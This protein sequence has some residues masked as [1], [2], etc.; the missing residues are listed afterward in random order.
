LT[1]EQQEPILNGEFR[2][3]NLK[4]GEKIMAI[5]PEEVLRIRTFL[6]SLIQQL[7]QGFREVEK[8][9]IIGLRI[10]PKIAP[11]EKAMLREFAHKLLLLMR[12]YEASDI[13]F[14]GP[15]S[16]SMIWL[17]VYGQK[18]PLPELGRFSLDEFSILIQC[19]LQETQQKQLYK[20][21]SIDFSYVV[22]LPDQPRQRYRATVYFEMGELALNM[23][24]IQTRLRPYESYGFHENVSRTLSLRYNKEGLIL[25]TGITGSGKTTT[26]DAII[27]LNNREVE[28]HIIVLASPIEFIHQSQKCIIRQREVGLDTL[29]FK[30]GVIEALHQDPDIIIIGEM[31]DPE[32]IM[33]V[34]EAADSGH[35]VFSTLHTASAVES[36]ER[37]IA[38]MPSLEQDRVRN[39]LADTLRCV[40]SQKLVPGINGK[41]ALAKEIMIMT[42][43]VKAAIKNNNLSEVYQ[44]VN[45]GKQHGMLTMEQD[46]RRLL[47]EEKISPETAMSFA[48]NKR[49][50]EQLLNADII[51]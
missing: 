35:K 25:V 39:R 10:L 11:R 37:I 13:E 17:R 14:G 20:N 50:M 18:R 7:P 30:Q 48:N 44:M 21:R 31:R 34:L 3:V 27:D 29:S 47:L 15:G 32:T 33:T 12:E 26:L 28:G 45:E 40:I 41:L 51:L 5:H 38:E 42:S 19:L 36:I 6:N 46:L 16:N 8:Q 43:S 9:V 4:F 23:R 1:E 22:A 49:L 24:A 2:I